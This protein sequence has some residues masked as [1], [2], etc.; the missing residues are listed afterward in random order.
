MADKPLDDSAEE[1]KRRF[2]EALERHGTA[3]KAR[4][5]H[6]EGRRKVRGM[7][8]SVGQRPYFRRKTG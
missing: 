4:Q 1:R 7:N 2:R 3:S 6:E 8:G 5:A